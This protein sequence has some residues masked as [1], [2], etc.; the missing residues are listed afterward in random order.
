MQKIILLLFVFCLSIAEAKSQENNSNTEN[1]VDQRD[2]LQIGFKAG[3][4]FSNVYDAKG[5]Q[6]KA[7]PKF[8]FVGGVFLSIPIGKYLGIQPEVLFSQKGFKATGSILGSSYKFTRTTNYIDI[9][10]LIALKPI[11]SVTILGGPQYS[12]LIKQKD[13]FS[14]AILSTTQEQEFNNDN[15]RKN[16]LCILGGIDINCNPLV[17]S[18]RAGWDFMNNNGDGTSSTPRYKNVWYQL[19]LGLKF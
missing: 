8:G 18:A 16:T 7:D 9:P 4:N 10:L 6:F 1:N 14:N 12:Y 5:D 11:E 13:E 3:A 2:K 15:I 17:I 19:T